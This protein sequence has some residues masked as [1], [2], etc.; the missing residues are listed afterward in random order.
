MALGSN[1]PFPSVLVVE[2][3]VPATPAA[4]NQRV[5]IDSADHKFKR[6]NSGGSVTTIEGGAGGSAL[7]AVASKT[8]AYTLTT[9]DGVILGDATGGTFALTLPTAVGNTGVVFQLTKKDIS[10]NIVT[11]NTTSAQTIGANSATSKILRRADDTL[12]VVSDGANWQIRDQ[13]LSSV[14]QLAYLP[15]T[16]LFNATAFS[17]SSWQDIT[18]NQTFS[19]DDAASVIEITVTGN[20]RCGTA[21]SIIGT[22]LVVDSAGTP[23]NAL[24]G[25]A[26]LNTSDYQNA[27]AGAGTIYLTG[28]ATGSHTVKVQ[29]YPS[30]AGTT[31]Y[32]R[33]ATFPNGE[34]IQIHAVER[35]N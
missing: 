26:A 23:V 16:D 34:Y 11:V 1:N 7:L 14:V 4:G 30:G 13:S 8:A 6:V 21:G 25:G 28:L 31:V 32:I 35:K 18:S 17:A 12:H 24:L 2:G 29:L 19:V 5:Y 33:A 10:A 15:A 20:I 27:L 3:T 22:R 9:A